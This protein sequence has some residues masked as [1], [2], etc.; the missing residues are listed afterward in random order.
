MWCVNAFRKSSWGCSDNV[1]EKELQA[2]GKL[3]GGVGTKNWVP[4]L[5]GKGC[6]KIQLFSSLMPWAPIS[7]PLSHGGGRVSVRGHVPGVFKKRSIDAV[8]K[9]HGGEG[10]SRESK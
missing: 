1:C 9:F 6:L 7:K 8:S 3:G 2:L 5:T 10:Q 4:D